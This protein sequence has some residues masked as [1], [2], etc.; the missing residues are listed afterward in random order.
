MTLRHTE[1]SYEPSETL[2]CYIAL[3][4]GTAFYAFVMVKLGSL[5]SDLGL[6]V[7]L[8]L[9]LMAVVSTARWLKYAYNRIMD[10]L[11]APAVPSLRRQFKSS[12]AALIAS[13]LFSEAT[14]YRA[15]TRDLKNCQREVIIESPFINKMRVN[16]LSSTLTKLVNCK[17]KVTVY[18]RH[19]RD[20]EF[21]MRDQ[22][23]TA[24]DLLKLTGARVKLERGYHH[25]KIAI[26]D[27]MVLWEGSLNILSQWGSIEMMRRIES[28]DL[29]GQVVR[30]TGIRNKLGMMR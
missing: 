17:V 22:A 19:P 10:A 28:E 29:A 15:F 1:L 9:L 13:K 24:I 23:W 21:Y 3:L 6:V 18:T 27:G 12:P 14:F 26:L 5:I 4:A 11:T 2:S 25:R 16:Q 20:L 8:F 7:I 30:F